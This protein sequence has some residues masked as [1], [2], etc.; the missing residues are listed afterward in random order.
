M[1]YIKDGEMV[2]DRR[3]TEYTDG[4]DLASGLALMLFEENGKISSVLLD[5]EA[6]DAV[7]IRLFL[8]DGENQSVFEKVYDSEEKKENPSIQGRMDDASSVS[9][10]RV[11]FD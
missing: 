8:L 10:W 9:I 1:I 4:Q 7:S 11:R 6:A 3:K 2:F 5:K